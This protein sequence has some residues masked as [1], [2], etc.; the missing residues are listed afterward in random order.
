[1]NATEKNFL[2]HTSKQA[3]SPAERCPILIQQ[4]SLLKVKIPVIGIACKTPRGGVS[5][6]SSRSRKRMLE[7]FACLDS[8]RMKAKTFVTLTYPDGDRPPAFDRSSL[9]LKNFL[10]RIKR[11]FPEASGLWRREQEER[12]SGDHVG[13]VYPHFHI[14]FFNLPFF[15]CDEVNR[16]WRDVLDH[17]GYARTEIKSVKDWRQA[18]GY[19]AKYM[20]KP[21]QPPQ[22]AGSDPRSGERRGRFQPPAAA[23]EVSLVYVPYW[24]AADEEMP[25]EKK[26]ETPAPD[27]PALTGRHWG[28]F[29]RA[30]LPLAQ[31][32]SAKI[33]F[34]L[35]D[36]IALEA[37]R[38]WNGI[39]PKQSLGFTL[40]SEE[41]AALFD[42]AM[43]DAW[44]DASCP[45][46]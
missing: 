13:V 11:R 7:T 29:N 32:R 8:D 36:L 16:H 12:K 14:L 2:H 23:D 1:M 22:A 26:E 41:A 24:A 18:F 33:P 19:V 9:D 25:E 34:P 3:N 44:E 17:D 37:S 6:F 20:A 46:E 43:T 40:F 45:P 10:K 30:A 5:S 35:A 42:R 38:L 28:V 21:L 27:T 15:D 4:G 39:D 31:R